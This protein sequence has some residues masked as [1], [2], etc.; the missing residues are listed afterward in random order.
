M[1][2]KILLM[3]AVTYSYRCY[4]LSVIGFLRQNFY[5]AREEEEGKLFIVAGSC[6]HHAEKT[7]FE[8]H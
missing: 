1:K 7:G 6:S 2:S 3:N 4:Y 5:A 8:S